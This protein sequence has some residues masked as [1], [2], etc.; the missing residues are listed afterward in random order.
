MLQA[1][2]VVGF[3]VPMIRKAWFFPSP[4]VAERS[5]AEPVRRPS[6]D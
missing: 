6:T 4:R 2:V 3:A 5:R 1:I